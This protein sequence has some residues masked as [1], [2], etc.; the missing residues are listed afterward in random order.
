VSPAVEPVADAPVHELVRAR[1]SL[2]PS[3]PA[4][5]HGDATT[6]YGALHDAVACLAH[7]LVAAGADAEVPVAVLAADPVTVVTAMLAILEAGAAFVLLDTTLP[8]E[9][10]REQL[11]LLEPSLM[12]VADE[13]AAPAERLRET[14]PAAVTI[15]L[16]AGAPWRRGERLRTAAG[17]DRNGLAY[18]TFTSGSTGEPKPIAGR[19][20]G[21]DHFV[22][23]EIET[24]GIVPGA[25]VSALTTPSFDAFL[26][27]VFAPLCAGA[28][29]VAPRDRAAT[30][31]RAELGSWIEGRGLTHVHC[32]PT[33]FRLLLDDLAPDAFP[34]LRW[35]LLAGEA[36]KP[37]DVARWHGTF[38]DRIRL[39][40]LYGPSETTMTKFVHVIAGT[41]AQRA[42]VP[43][44][45]PMPG[46]R[47]IVVDER[48]R[49]CPPG[50]VG[51]I[52]IRT[53]YRSLGYFRRPDLTAAAFVPNPFGAD[54]SDLV[55]RTGD[56]GR[57]L[58]DG[59]YE[60]IGRRDGQVKVGGVR[61]EL[62]E[63]D[64]ALRSHPSVTD[65]AVVARDDDGEPASL[66]AYVVLRGSLTSG[67]LRAYL[68]RRL[69]TAMIPA[70]FVELDALPRTVTGKLDRRALPR[71]KRE[72][73]EQGFVAPATPVEE[74]LAGLWGDVLHVERVGALDDFF[75][76]GGHSLLAMQLIARIEETFGVAL[77]LRELFEAGRLRELAAR[78]ECRREHPRDL[79]PAVERVSRTGPLPLSSL[80]RRLWFLE[81][82]HPGKPVYH[83]PTVVAIEGP[84]DEKVLALALDDVVARHEGLR[85]SFPEEDGA[86]VLR[87]AQAATVP[88]RI[89][90]ARGDDVGSE[91]VRGLAVEEMRRPFDLDRPPLVRALLIRCRA[92]CVLVLTVH[93]L[94]ADA[95]SVAVLVRDVAAAYSRRT[96]GSASTWE[97]VPIREPDPAARARAADDGAG[98][99]YWLAQLAGLQPL[100]L[101]I[102]RARP[103]VPT[104]EG[105]TEEFELGRELTAAVHGFAGRHRATAF[106][107]LLAA[108]YAVLRRYTGQEDVAVATPVANR[109]S[110][111][112]D[113]VVGLFANTLVLR[114]DVSGDPSFAELVRRTR[115][116]A[117]GAFAHQDV[118]LDEI[119]RELQPDRDPA[120]PAFFPI[121]FALQNLPERDAAIDGLTFRPLALNAAISRFD[122]TVELAEVDGSLHARFEYS[123]DLFEPVTVRRLAAAYITLLGGALEAEA[124][125][126]TRL[127]LLDDAGSAALV[128]LGRSAAL[129]APAAATVDVL[130]ARIAAERP[131]AVAVVCGATAQTYGELDARANRLAHHLRARG[132]G[133]GTLVALYLE[134]SVDA[135]VAILG[136]LKAGAGY[137]PLDAG[138]PRDRLAMMIADT[139]A[140]AVVSTAALAGA[141]PRSGPSLVL[142]D[143]DADAIAA[144]PDDAPAV[145]NDPDATAYVIYTSGSTGRP[146]GVVTS[147][148]N[149]VTLLRA[150]EPMIGPGADDVWLLFHS[151]AFD[152]SVWEIWGALLYGGRLVVVP[153]LVARA[154]AALV[155]LLAAERVTI[156]NQTPSAFWVLANALEAAGN[157]LPSALRAVLVGGEWFEFRRL[158]AWFAR[159]G[160]RRP[161]LIHVYGI[162][163]TTVFVTAREVTEDDTAEPAPSVVG[164]PIPGYELYLLDAHGAPVPHNVVG[165][166]YVGGTGLAAGY[167]SR[168][169]L[170]AAR[171]VP[172][173]FSGRS[174]A[175]LY[176]SGDLAR[177]RWNG[178][179]EYVGRSDHQ[180]K[181]RG[182]RIETGE[183]EACIASHPTV[184]EVAVLLRSDGGAARLVA[185]VTPRGG[186]VVPL[187]DVRRWL[188]ARL[189]AY[190]IPASFVVIAELP[191]TKNG[192][193]DRAALPAPA[194]ERP[195]LSTPFVAPRTEREAVLSGIWSEVLG[196]A[197][198]GIHDN[199][200][201]LGG[202]SIRSIEVCARA[203]ALG[204][205]ITA[206]QLF[207]LQTVEALADQSR[208]DVPD[209]A[210]DSPTPFALVAR[211]DIA[212]LPAGLEDAFPAASLQ[213]GM[214]YHS[215]LDA[216][217][218]R[219]HAIE[220]CRLAVAFDEDAFRGALDTIVGRHPMLRA[221]FDLGRYREP[222][223]L[224]H[225]RVETPLRVE[226]L[227]EHAT[228]ERERVL[229]LRL[230]GERRRARPLSEPPLFD[231]LVHRLDARTLQFT[232]S[233]HHAIL[234][235]WS[236]ATLMT[237]L[238]EEYA[239][240]LR[241]E[242]SR[243]LPPPRAAYRDFVAA[244]RDESALANPRSFWTSYLH[245]AE[246]T[247]LAESPGERGAG[248]IAEDVVFDPGISQSLKDL[249]RSC[250][251]TLKSVLLAAHA[252]ALG[253]LT[254]REDVVTGM[255]AHARPDAVDGERVLGLFLNTVPVRLRARGPSWRR[256]VVDALAAEIEIQPHLR[257]PLQRMQR[258]HGGAPFDVVF[259]FASY[260]EHISRRLQSVAGIELVDGHVVDVTNFPLV[261]NFTVDPIDGAVR[262]GLVADAAKVS[263]PLLETIATIYRRVVE[264]AAREDDDLKTDGADDRLR[265]RALD[266]VHEMRGAPDPCAAI[267]AA[268]RAHGGE[269]AVAD[270]QSTL[271]YD[272]FVARVETLAGALRAAGVGCERR[273]GIC[274]PRDARLVVA[275]VSV[276]AAGGAYVPLDPEY[277][278]DRLAMMLAEAPVS[279]LLTDSGVIGRLPAAAVSERRWCLDRPD[280]V[281]AGPALS[282]GAAAH[283]RAAAAYTIFTSGSSGRPKGVVVSRGALGCFLAAIRTEVRVGPHDRLLAV[284][285]LPFDIAALELLLPLTVGGCVAVASAEDT[286]DPVRLGARLADPALTTMQATPSTWRMLVETG[287]RPVRGFRVL[288]GGEALPRALADA[289]LER[290]AELWNLYGPTETTIWSSA[291]RVLP[292]EA[293]PVALGVP[294]AGTRL[295]VLDRAGRPA[296]PGVPGELAIGGAGI[297]RGYL[298]DPRRTAER[299]VPDPFA[300]VPG[301][302]L[303]RTGDV[304]REVPGFGLQFLGRADEQLKIRGHRIEPGEIEAALAAHRAIGS[305]A[306][307]ARPSGN[308]SV[309]VAFFTSPFDSPPS[310]SELRA[311]LAQRLPQPMI[312][313]AFVRVDV[314]PRTLNGKADRRALA[315][316][317]VDLRAPGRARSALAPRDGLELELAA[318][319]RAVLA[320]SDV[321]VRDH[322]FLDL[323]GDSLRAVQLAAA[324]R[325]RVAPAFALADLVSGGT[326][327][328]CATAIRR[329]NGRLGATLLPLQPGG[330]QPPLFCVHSA[331]G[332]SIGY[333]GLALALGEDQPC[334]G[335]DARGT[336]PGERPRTSVDAMVNAYVALVR[337]AQPHGPYRLAGHSFGGLVA[338]E[339][340][341]Q[342]ASAGERIDLLALLDTMLPDADASPVLEDDGTLALATA[343][344]LERFFGRSLDLESIAAGSRAEVES[345]V[346]ERLAGAGLFPADTAKPLLRGLS[347]VQQANAEAM[348]RFRPEPYAGR[349]LLVR[350]ALVAEEDA[351]RM[352]RRARHDPTLG[353][354]DLCA[355]GVDVRFVDGDHVT[356]LARA[357]AVS[358]IAA[359]LRTA[360]GAAARC[361]VPAGG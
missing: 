138:S 145:T 193:L 351:P 323:G 188:E 353:W 116:T 18:V 144:W 169:G 288:S 304:V 251:V 359:H 202:D 153:Y 314:L 282:L 306:V 94:V 110:R 213:L 324:I 16:G 118:A 80:Q 190:M 67:E 111:A 31:T 23:W 247:A 270:E 195:A 277:P 27:D 327:E 95:W 309:L 120:R 50:V 358:Q 43:V 349:V 141:L 293:G 318:V 171:F 126:L 98:R 244:E 79:R 204:V 175:R 105:R 159:Y 168:P 312:P 81:R 194:A 12:L 124:T 10:L 114:T 157:A 301:A 63:I 44:G 289:L 69:P 119:V 310:A 226:D 203:R 106:M 123:V 320:T 222:L 298:N 76:T 187:S 295:A 239:A 84:L 104:F 348:A 196:V 340:A 291:Q 344:T 210:G 89:C 73:G 279:V 136:T 294:L 173:P 322:F 292:G 160:D 78:I 9:R 172:D 331:V 356:M 350:A 102:D 332:L 72:A 11:R 207:R 260:A 261:A 132:A 342:L 191:R 15:A 107:V 39:V 201:L 149:V 36:V 70:A 131:G 156:L 17:R 200:F 162:T 42:S 242:P 92:A 71:P 240:R 339:M 205:G 352:P 113:D 313:A 347:R 34:A 208:S 336:D 174:G 115:D 232:L 268:A 164:A 64:A 147:H 133:R 86:A 93:H 74:A 343:R 315:T 302:R 337:A 317:P 198:V 284:T 258:E 182:Y 275:V 262:L 280:D 245:G 199:F 303:Y 77:P 329:A 234:D 235:G 33:V 57:I 48:D 82:L 83:V 49:A 13:S 112:L 281:P 128:E 335:I 88:L 35:V 286:S 300:D 51:E 231:I 96:S 30:L 97:P 25:R 134:P 211:E 14:L 129:G 319:W 243:L 32:V 29:M 212:A 287:W 263:A 252:R 326:I 209:A 278:R 185:Y 151:Y 137:V 38:G 183:I 121:G 254:G 283:E 62:G 316:L 58:E 47:A 299:F 197:R 221:S 238:F 189:P 206:Q 186:R 330:S 250:G 345:A 7:R 28:T 273:V 255:I 216:Q 103:A 21:I 256:A 305:C 217:A 224:V 266:R 308:E 3:A 140:T 269:P 8:D 176:R 361:A 117:L 225:R 6:T 218:R 360:G 271:T 223:V 150:M 135:I 333:R 177:R 127:P 233:F 1:A 41:D 4:I 167:L 184:A 192:K 325:E 87:I 40:N 237:E 154:P 148:R 354:D 143:A 91:T 20:A 170:T 265:L 90:D 328:A 19:L 276:L 297:A 290:G 152:F 155:E 158:R 142:L 54:A 166:I 357:D 341:R 24:F 85:A 215:D 75:E 259:N 220:S 241:G 165:E 101:P 178:E 246:H 181:L 46:A 296:P 45:R 161:R 5:E 179:L 139:N 60:L 109:P 311:W 146:K 236:V 272:D 56:F 257:Y 61:I 227:R 264:A 65:V 108:F 274:L 338:F 68:A 214:L 248:P 53:P 130:F 100:E 230:E 180:V 228:H 37:S 249:A 307:V 55:Y 2:S 26:R 321:G 219:Y 285:G 229:A 163:E 125:P 355:G 267:A 52:L 99:A 22:R 59:S 346:A 66:C 334:F 253:L 122:L